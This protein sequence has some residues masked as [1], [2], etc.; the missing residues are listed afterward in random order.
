MRS[1]Y[2]RSRRTCDECAEVWRERMVEA[3]A[4]ASKN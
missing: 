3:A 1:M 4:E 2:A